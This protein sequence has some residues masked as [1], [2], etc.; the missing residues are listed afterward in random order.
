MIHDFEALYMIRQSDVDAFR[1][2]R[3]KYVRLIWKRAHTFYNDQKPEGVVVE[4]LYAE[5]CIGFYESL[6]GFSELKNVGFA[7][8]VS[9]CV[10]SH[11][12][13]LLRRCRGKSYRLLDSRYSLD[14]SVAEDGTLSLGDLQS[15]TDQRNDPS[16]MAIVYDALQYQEAVFKEQSVE[17]VE[18]YILRDAGYSYKEIAEHLNLSEKKVDNLIQKV[19]KSLKMWP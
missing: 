15:D 5:G 2:M 4:D 11:I 17:S 10:E 16:Y 9:L 12:K 3:E 14:I 1:Y 6:Y 13:T 18:A 7:Y 8:Y 19:R